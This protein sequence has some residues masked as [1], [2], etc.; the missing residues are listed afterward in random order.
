[1][2]TSCTKVGQSLAISRP[3]T[4][5]KEHLSFLRIQKHMVFTSKP[6]RSK[7]STSIHTRPKPL[8]KTCLKSE[9][10]SWFCHVVSHSDTPLHPRL[11]GLTPDPAVYEAAIST[12][13]KN[14]DA[15]N[16]ILGKQKYL[17]GNVS[18]TSCVPSDDA[19]LTDVFA[20]NNSR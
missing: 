1:M 6:H 10:I 14:L 20:G 4:P 7:P 12:L 9:P 5:I 19:I 2:D 8:P 17:A 3:S 15:Y 18:L 16:T 11:R 13:D